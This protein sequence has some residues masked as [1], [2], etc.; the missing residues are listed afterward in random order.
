MASGGSETAWWELAPEAVLGELAGG[1]KGG[2]KSSHGGEALLSEGLSAEVVEERRAAHGW[3]ELEKPPSKPLWKLVLE[4]FDDALVKILILA[5]LVS[6]VL[7]L[8]EE[9][10]AVRAESAAHHRGGDGGIMADLAS[11][12]SFQSLKAFIEP[13]VIV[14]ILLLNAIVGVWQ[15]SNAEKALEALQELNSADCACLRD[16]KWVK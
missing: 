15:E 10:E 4:Q 1:G 14:L 11:L 13:G 16:G 12:L 5:A 8:S 3:N 2:K 6:F 7:A 9:L